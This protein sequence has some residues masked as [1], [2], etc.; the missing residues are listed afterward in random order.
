MKVNFFLPQ[1]SQFNKSTHL[2]CLVFLIVFFLFR[3]QYYSYNWYNR[4]QLLL[5]IAP[6]LCNILTTSFIVF[7]FIILFN[8]N[9]N[10]NDLVE[11]LFIRGILVN[12]LICLNFIDSSKNI[13]I[14]FVRINSN[15]LPTKILF[16]C[17]LSSYLIV[18]ISVALFIFINFYCEHIVMK[19]QVNPI[20]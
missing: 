8:L 17:F 11:V 6:L 18:S 2:A 14:F 9:S 15:K 3:L 10:P 19:I 4:F 12:C 1:T 7:Y 13:K 5:N 20:T 16:Y